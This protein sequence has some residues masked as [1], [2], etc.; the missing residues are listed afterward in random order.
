MQR[1]PRRLL[2]ALLSAAT[3]LLTACKHTQA[4]YP[5][6]TYDQKQELRAV[7]NNDEDTRNFDPE[8]RHLEEWFG[9]IEKLKRQL[10]D[11]WTFV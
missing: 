5:E 4:I 9:R 8:C 3:I 6:M 2:L 10:N 11:S 7:C 1:K